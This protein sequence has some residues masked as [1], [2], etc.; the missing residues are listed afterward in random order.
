MRSAPR[1]YPNFDKLLAMMTNEGG[2]ETTV[3]A[4]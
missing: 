4:Q 2:R 3:E 1:P